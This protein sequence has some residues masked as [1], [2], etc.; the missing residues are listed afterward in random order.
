[1][2][3][4]PQWFGDLPERAART[5]PTMAVVLLIGES[6]FTGSAGSHLRLSGRARRSRFVCVGRE[7]D[8]MEFRKSSLDELLAEPSRG[9]GP[10]PIGV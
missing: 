7:G 9:R 3:S 10:G 5:R 8:T 6:T 1:M 4:D 2:C